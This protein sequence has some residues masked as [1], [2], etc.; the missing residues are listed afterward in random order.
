MTPK[1][2]PTTAYRISHYTWDDAGNQIASTTPSRSTT[3]ATYN[4][5]G[6]TTTIT[7]PAGTTTFDHDG[8]GRQTETRTPQTAARL[9][10]TTHSTT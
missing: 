9:S 1:C 8:L 4:T 7:D 10:P 2:C 6:E 3:S 5:A